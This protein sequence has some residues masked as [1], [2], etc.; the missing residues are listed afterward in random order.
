M[1]Y[2][3]ANRCLFI[4]L[5]VV[6]ACK[7]KSADETSTRSVQASE[8][9]D[10]KSRYFTKEDECLIEISDTLQRDKTSRALADELC[11]PRSQIS[12]LLP[13]PSTGT[14]NISVAPHLKLAILFDASVSLVEQDSNRARFGA[15]KEY[16][17]AIFA[18]KKSG[19][20]S[21][22]EIKVYP[23]RY[24][25]KGEHSLELKN[26]TTKSEFTK[27]VDTLIGT[28]DV[29][30]KSTAIVDQ[31]GLANLRAYG[32]VGS[33]NYL[34][35]FAEAQKFLARETAVALKPN[36]KT[37][38]LKQMLI[39]SDGLPFTFNDNVKNTIHTSD[40]Q[41]SQIAD[42]TL[43]NWQDNLFDRREE[44]DYHIDEKLTDCVVKNFFHPK[45]SC[46]RPKSTDMGIS[47]TSIKAWDDPLNHALGMIQHSHV[48]NEEKEDFAIYSVH[49]NNCKTKTAST[50]F[51]ENFLCQKISENFFRSFSDGFVSV[52]NAAELKDKLTKKTLK[53]QFNLSYSTGTATLTDGTTV[54]DKLIF[55]KDSSNEKRSIVKVDGK[56]VEKNNGKGRTTV[57]ETT[58]D[59]RNY[60]DDTLKASLKMNKFN[61]DYKL[62]YNFHFD[63]GCRDDG[64]KFKKE[65]AN[66]SDD[67]VAL[68]VHKWQQSGYRAW[69]VLPI[70]NSGDD[71]DEDPDPPPPPVVVTCADIKTK[72]SCGKGWTWSDMGTPPDDCCVRLSEAPE[73]PPVQSPPDIGE[74]DHCINCQTTPPIVDDGKGGGKTTT[75]VVTCATYTGDKDCTGKGGQWIDAN[76]GTPPDACCAEV[77]GDDSNPTKDPVSSPP[78][79]DLSVIVE[80]K[81]LDW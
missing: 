55:Y 58:F 50:K 81:K 52:S 66:R 26:D 56:V 53:S 13:V 73:N 70:I 62:A 11:L 35:S 18:K 15:L 57:Q 41:L 25:N 65:V 71:L 74:D 64:E 47:S 32:A 51:D 27:A 12:F 10:Q 20:I 80:K 43:N 49:L 30:N 5:L 36:E 44:S 61:Y 42:W 28:E 33:T 14:R 59:Y 1:S 23:F 68:E 8:V 6:A 46:Q 60:N 72:S 16:L 29:G 37:A 2:T 69:C 34:N 78:M 38:E 63:D 77:G 22:A 21:S 45:D 19:Q 67:V 48:I 40:C 39:F 75:T 17:M 4:V 9:L 54:D 7:I 79:E 24:C 76:L 31:T 3:I